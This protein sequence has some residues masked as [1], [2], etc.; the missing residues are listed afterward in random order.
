[1]KE[2]LDK[3]KSLKKDQIMILFL[4]GVLLLV[5]T[6]PQEEQTQPEL[7]PQTVES[8]I[9]DTANSEDPFGI[10][11]LENR[12]KRILAQVEGIG[13][14]E[15]MLTLKS[16]GRRIVEKDVEQSRGEEVENQEGT[17][18][19]SSE[20]KSNENTVYQKDSYGNEIP[21]VMEQLAPEIDGVLVIA[22]GA[23]NGSVTS[24]ITEAV[25]ALFGVPAH[26]IKVMKMK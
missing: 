1:M 10:T 20:I 8:E 15:V 6:L 5:I 23:G 12:L 9:Q 21:Y 13:Q 16:G 25:M 2:W 18:G 26:K 19:S 7:L 3:I 22:Q 17:S 14:T 11:E 24:E 4:A